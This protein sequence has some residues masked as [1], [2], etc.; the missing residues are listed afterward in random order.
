[1]SIRRACTTDEAGELSGIAPMKL[2]AIA[3]PIDAP[4]PTPVPT[5]TAADAATTT[6][7][8]SDVL[9][10]S[11]VTSPPASMTLFCASAMVFDRITFCE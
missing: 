11:S 4:R 3:M 5:P 8:R 9:T 10:A 1:M 2:R 6:D 7:D